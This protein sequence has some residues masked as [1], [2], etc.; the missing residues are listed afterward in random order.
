MIIDI[1][2]N[3]VVQDRGAKIIQIKRFLKE[4]IFEVQVKLV[5]GHPNQVVGFS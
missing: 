1:R 2:K 5:L 3:Y 4:I